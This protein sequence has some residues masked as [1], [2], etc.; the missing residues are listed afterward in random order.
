MAGGRLA[1][2]FAAGGLACG[3]EGGFVRGKKYPVVGARVFIDGC[4]SLRTGSI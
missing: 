2:V 4:H 3:D 1:L